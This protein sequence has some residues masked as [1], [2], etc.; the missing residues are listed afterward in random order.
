MTEGR[1]HD[2]EGSWEVGFPVSDPDQLLLALGL[3]EAPFRLVSGSLDSPVG[4]WSASPYADKSV[5]HKK[6]VFGS[7]W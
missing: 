4:Q 1:E 6:P 2:W 5:A 7:C 3:M